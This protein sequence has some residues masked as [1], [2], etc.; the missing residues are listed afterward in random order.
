MH[1][2]EPEDK[3]VVD[4]RRGKKGRILCGR[5]A[6]CPGMVGEWRHVGH[7][8]RPEKLIPN[9]S[10]PE[11]PKFYLV[12]PHGYRLEKDTGYYAVLKPERDEQGHWVRKRS[13]RRTASSQVRTLNLP[14]ERD[15]HPDDWEILQNRFDENA[16]P[17]ERYRGVFGQ[18]PIVPTIVRCV[19]CGHPNRV[20]ESLLQKA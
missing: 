19:V 13:S 17:S 9:W 20:E 14:S 18:Q 16:P 4:A 5:R 10:G 2:G 3:A 7:A 8:I 15:M 1:I 12:H 6:E 11:N